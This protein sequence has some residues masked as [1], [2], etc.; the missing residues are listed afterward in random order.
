MNAKR[1]GPQRR[2]VVRGAAWATPVV[3]LAT[4]APT[5]AQSAQACDDW[6]LQ[7]F[8]EEE[9]TAGNG[10]TLT[11]E[12]MVPGGY[13]TFVGG[14]FWVIGDPTASPAD[15]P[16]GI[17][18]ATANVDFVSGNTY[19]FNYLTRI[20]LFGA[21]NQRPVTSDLRIGGTVVA[22]SPRSSPPGG[23]TATTVQYTATSS[24]PMAVEF[25]YAWGP[26]ID[27]HS[28]LIDDL[29]SSCASA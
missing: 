15:Q 20:S 3:I 5:V 22:G 10:W 19:T 2:Q 29:T 23:E 6:D 11:S 8:P 14:R 16:N 18:K 27:G 13:K 12:N 7:A 24:G 4:A 17:V 1:S 26:G 21:D 28:I 25:R 9:T